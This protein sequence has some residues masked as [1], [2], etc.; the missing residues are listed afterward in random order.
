M[1]K[2]KILFFI[3]DLSYGGAEKVL[4]NL[5]NNMDTEKFDITLQ[6]LFDQ[7]VNKQ[8]LK[9]QIRYKSWKKRSFR[10]YTRLLA[11][12]SPK[13][14]YQR[15]VKDR[16]DIVV[17]YLEGVTARILSG[18]PFPDTKKVS[19]IHIELNDREKFSKTFRNYAEAVSCYSRYDRIV[20]VSE[21]VRDIFAS[22]LCGEGGLTAENC[23]PLDVLYNTN[24]TAQ[25][26]ERSAEP[27]DDPDFVDDGRIRV[28]SVA[29]IMPSKGYDRLVRVHKR[30][31]DE[32]YSHH[33][34]ILGVGEGKEKLEAY[35]AEN[36]LSDSF[37]F[38]GFRDNPYKY[39]AACDLY[40]CSS[41]REGFS[42]AVTESLIVGTPVVSTCCS[43]AYELLGK[44][45][46][47]GI[48]TENS[49]D[50]IYEGM[51]TMLKEEALRRQYAEKAK[52]RG[53]KFSTENTV[54]AVEKMF[55]DL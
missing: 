18:C 8:Y 16:Y 36:G 30:L 48:V 2:K 5:V 55:L 3:P 26:L 43:G 31:T 38:L 29:K 10:G 34:Y 23:P 44:E 45:N 27:I 24:E 51:K 53:Q 35:L 37:T 54:L 22:G 9:P 11:L 41:R 21:T 25:I 13:Q 17:S 4:V 52:E 49:E 46:E 28:C 15:I 39:V 42:T 7:G 19:W 32:G 47:Y 1:E 20:C 50:G 12:F 40:V 6:T 14:L 33:V